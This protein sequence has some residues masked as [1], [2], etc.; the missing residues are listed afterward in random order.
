MLHVRVT[1]LYLTAAGVVKNASNPVTCIVTLDRKKK[2]VLVPDRDFS[3]PYNQHPIAL[4]DGYPTHYRTDMPKGGRSRVFLPR[5]KEGE[6]PNV[7]CHITVS[8]EALEGLFHLPLIE[9]ARETGLCPTTFK[10]ACRRFDLETWPFRKGSSS[11]AGQRREQASMALDTRF[12][13]EARHDAPAFQLKTFAPHDA[14]SYIKAFARGCVVIRVPLPTPEGL[15]TTGAC[16]MAQGG[17]TPLDAG[18]LRE[19]SCVEA[20]MEYLDLECSISEADAT[21]MLSNDY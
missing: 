17:A 18:P 9:A 8:Y 20:V 14:P 7:P 6:D 19:K 3:R 16:G 1:S 11:L 12:Y 13:D 2:I 15:P 10:K 4:F 21:S 5:R